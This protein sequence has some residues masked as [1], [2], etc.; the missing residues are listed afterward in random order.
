M[1][2]YDS[3]LTGI[4]IT[5]AFLSFQSAVQA[6]LLPDV[7]SNISLLMT[8]DLPGSL[9]SDES[10][11][12]SLYE[13]LSKSFSNTTNTTNIPAEWKNYTSKKHGF[14]IEY[15]SNVTSIIEGRFT[16]Y[17]P[18]QDLVIKY[19]L[20]SFSVLESYKDSV[21]LNQSVKSFIDYITQE[22][23]DFD[24][25]YILISGPDPIKIDNETAYKFVLSRV[26]KESGRAI[27]V[28]EVVKVAHGPKEF[29]LMLT[30]APN[31]FDRTEK[32]RNHMIE[33]IKWID[34]TS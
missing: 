8:P 18:D 15:L 33:S 26:D 5:T 21:P 28:Q 16:K 2:R 32:M 20:S 7:T 13:V 19:P 4:L 14:S 1:D 3:L 12:K 25:Y 27:A 34:K 24:G 23:L 10:S 17:D 6:Q 29:Q 9:T 30:A 11:N 31:D 22:D